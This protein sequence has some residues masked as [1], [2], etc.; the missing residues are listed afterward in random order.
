MT[1]RARLERV[2][3]I[4]GLGNDLLAD[5][6]FGFAVARELE[7]LFGRQVEVICSSAS[8]LALLDA[9]AGASQLLVLDTWQTGASAPGTLYRADEA[10]LPA[11]RGPSLHYVGLLDTL[12]LGRRL[13]MPMPSDLAIVAVEPA[14]CLTVGG[15]MSAAVEQAIP[16]AVALGREI[17]TA[18]LEKWGR[19]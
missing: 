2:I 4:L 17:V 7:R 16:A 18:W 14:D 1:G 12:A 15:P 5:D 9:L 19:E 13:Q 10:T 6:G 8:G 3:R 11:A